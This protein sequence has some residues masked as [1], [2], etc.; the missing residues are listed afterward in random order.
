MGKVY[1]V[2]QAEAN[3]RY[4]EKYDFYN[5]RFPKRDNTSPTDNSIGKDKCMEYAEKKGVSLNAL[6]LSLLKAEIEKN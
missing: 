4:R 3:A 2:S 5:V 6:I 1:T